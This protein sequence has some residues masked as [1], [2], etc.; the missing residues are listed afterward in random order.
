MTSVLRETRRVDAMG[1]FSRRVA[2]RLAEELGRRQRLV[3]L[4]RLRD[5]VEAPVTAAV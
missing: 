4:A 3:S 5:A 1:C 2:W